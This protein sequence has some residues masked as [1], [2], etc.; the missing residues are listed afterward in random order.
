[1]AEERYGAG[2]E[3]LRAA[4]ALVP[5]PGLILN[6]S[7][8]YRKWGGHC[9]EAFRALA[10]FW[11]EC[12]ED[13]EYR[14]AGEAERDVLNEACRSR[15]RLESTPP[16]PVSVDGK[17]KGRTPLDLRLRPGRYRVIT[18]GS[19]PLEMD[20][21]GETAE[22]IQL[23]AQD[24][25]PPPAR[26]RWGWLSAGI[27][28]AGLVGG[29][30]ATGLAVD[31]ASAVSDARRGGADPDTVDA[32]AGRRDRETAVAVA[33]FTTAVVGGVTSWWLLRHWGPEAP[34][35]R[36]DEKGFAVLIETST[37]AN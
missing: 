31:S 16:V 22:R 10:E 4:H 9:S 11:T 37:R 34:P 17:R 15:V 32:L 23:W 19:D 29:A 33:A 20:I 8:A 7:I 2:I 14:A 21:D 6:V 36:L 25:G 35:E 27:G 30:V 3:H 13:C 28:A 1:L 12:K 26:R 18:A 24:L 5:N